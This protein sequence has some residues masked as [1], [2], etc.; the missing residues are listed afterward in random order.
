MNPPLR[1][2]FRHA[3]HSMPAPFKPQ[4]AI[5]TVALDVDDHFLKSISLRNRKVGYIEFPAALLAVASI[6]LVKIPAKQRRL[7]APGPRTDLQEERLDNIVLGR[8]EL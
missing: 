2:G 3:L 8:Q 5:S 7:F 4:M 6:H 1:L